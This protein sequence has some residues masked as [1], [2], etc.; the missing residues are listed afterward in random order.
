LTPS[1]KVDRRALPE[2]EAPRREGVAPR[3]HVELELVRIW[4]ELLGAGSVGVRD[5]FFELG[6]HSLLAM[7][8]LGRVERQ[9]GVR[10]SPTALFQAP[11]VEGLAALVRRQAGPATAST[12]VPL[13]P[14][15]G[16]PVFWV[17][18]GVGTVYCYVPLVRHLGLDRP[19]YGLQA[20]GVA[21][22]EAPLD[23]IEDMAA[24]YLR[25]LRQV[26]PQGPYLL[27]GWSLGG[28]VAFEMALQLQAA[29]EEVELLALVD[30]VLVPAGHEPEAVSVLTAFARDLGLPLGHPALGAALASADLASADEGEILERLFG[31]LQQAGLLPPDLGLTEIR[32]LFEAF[33]SHVGALSRYRPASSWRGRL[34]LFVAEERLTGE[35][36]SPESSWQGR[37]TEGMEVFPLS[38]SHHTLLQEPHVQ[39]LA[40]YLRKLIDSSHL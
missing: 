4:E 20:R 14:G 39:T 25:E 15:V 35:V 13:Q 32:R 33:R 19:M 7:T 18:P 6:G 2:P 5:N 34:H 38:G 12:L 10:L 22:P 23:R 36:A 9:L 3:D 27:G 37:A 31:P 1:G 8:L 11:T 16:R 26:Q 24:F 30:S 21:G 40:A 29:G 17:H 28:V